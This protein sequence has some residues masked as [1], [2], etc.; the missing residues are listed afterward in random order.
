MADTLHQIKH[1]FI[2]SVLFDGKFGSL[3]LCV[4]A[5]VKAR[6]DLYGADLCGADLCGAN[7]SGASLYGADLCGADLSGADLRRADLRVTKWHGADLRGADLSGADLRR[8]DLRET[9][10]RDGITINRRPLFIDGLLWPVW[11][12]DEHMQIGCELHRLDEWAGFDDRRIAEMGNSEAVKFWKANKD[13]LLALAKADGRWP[14]K[15]T[16]AA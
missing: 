13:A 3:R 16:I 4:E 7:L 10:W 6:T 15:R 1:R 12:L 5:A 14:S 11:I 8:A 9:K 2:G